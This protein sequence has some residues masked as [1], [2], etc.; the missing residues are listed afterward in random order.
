MREHMKKLI[1]GL[2]TTQKIGALDN[3]TFSFRNVLIYLPSL[4]S[5]PQV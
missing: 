1:Y 5:N 3:I 2:D 4:P